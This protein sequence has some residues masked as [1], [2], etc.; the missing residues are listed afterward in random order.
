MAGDE[1]D[2]FI[3]RYQGLK[4]RIIQCTFIL[5]LSLCLIVPPVAV[6][7]MHGP[8]TP[9]L[10]G[11]AWLMNSHK[12]DAEAIAFLRTLPGEHVIVEAAGDDYRTR[13]ILLVE[14]VANLLAGFLGGV[15]QT[16]PYIGHP[17]YKAMGARAGYT[18]LTGIVIGLAAIFGV[19]GVIIDF[20]PEVVVAPILLFVGLA[21]TEQAFVASPRPVSYT[22]LTLPTIYS[23]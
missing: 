12:E 21:I 5:L 13:D 3:T 15:A 16:T 7:T 14:S 10:D 23:V 8:H 2:A 20:I 4:V 22:H 19:L 11:M 1:L 18:F 6:S 9:T 17:A